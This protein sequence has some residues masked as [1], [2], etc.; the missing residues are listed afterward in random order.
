M[1]NTLPT[2][3]AIPA[4]FSVISHNYTIEGV[5]RMELWKFR[6]LGS[7]GMSPLLLEVLLCDAVGCRILSS[8]HTTLYFPSIIYMLSSIVL[9][10]WIRHKH[11]LMNALQKTLICF[12][13]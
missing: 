6:M 3:A 7:I 9:C 11:I 12:F 5:Y 4:Q 13:N 2:S 1:Q 8:V 10:I